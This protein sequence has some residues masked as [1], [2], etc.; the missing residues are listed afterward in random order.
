MSTPHPD[1]L[2]PV[3][4]SRRTEQPFAPAGRHCRER[5]P[6]LVTRSL[7]VGLVAAG[8]IGALTACG[9]GQHAQTA[10]ERP[11]LDGAYGMS[12]DI[13]VQGVS[14]L[15]PSGDK[16]SA[17]S[18]VPLTLYLANAST[19]TD[20]LVNVSSP[21]FS[22]WT[23]TAASSQS[24][25]GSAS[26][27]P[28]SSATAGS[29]SSA[30][31]TA[32]SSAAGG[33]GSAQ[34]QTVPPAGA[35]GFGLTAGYGAASTPNEKSIL[36]TGLK[37]TLYSGEGV[38]VTFNFRHVDPVTLKVPVQLPAT[39]ASESVGGTETSGG[40]GLPPSELTTK[41]RKARP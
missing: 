6:G 19:R 16:W 24:S 10:E 33:G 38:K 37:R 11:T 17:G 14:L 12:G 21:D 28:S 25:S 34:P 5:N 30:S 41:P 15:A 7:A 2:S 40:A 29:S 35:V 26:A 22:G 9:A 18:S 8:A 4:T 36:L 23:V 13:S 32:S 27:S 3:R 1:T 39:P 31:P 20:A